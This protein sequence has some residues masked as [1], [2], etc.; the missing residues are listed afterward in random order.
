MISLKWHMD[1]HG[2]RPADQPNERYGALVDAMIDSGGLACPSL[3]TEFRDSLAN[4][5]QRLGT[6]GEP[7]ELASTCSEIEAQIDAWGR[8]AG[9]QNEKRTV[10]VRE[11]LVAMAEAAAAAS[12]RNQEHQRQFAA[13]SNQLNGMGDL[14]DLSQIRTLVRRAAADLKAG[15]ERMSQENETALTQMRSRLTEYKERMQAAETLAESD[16]LTGLLNRAGFSRAFQARAKLGS[17]FCVVVADLNHFKQLN[18]RYGHLTGDEALK[19]FAGEFRTQFRAG[20]AVA[21]WGGDEFVVLIQAS[22]KEVVERVNAVRRWA[23]GDYTLHSSGKP[24]KVH[25]EA[26]LGVGEWRPGMTLEQVFAAADEAMY[27]EKQKAPR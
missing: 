20:D 17:P 2:K 18:D 19:S 8:K 4:L 27:R 24:V 11:I 5:R 9:E 13:V 7:N 25:V 15:A 23:F 12:Q 22:N 3:A 26:A 1:R 21:R 16:S 6:S 14:S 10:E